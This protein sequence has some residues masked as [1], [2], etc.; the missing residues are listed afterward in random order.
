[1]IKSIKQRANEH[2]MILVALTLLMT[3]F[4]VIGLALFSYTSSQYSRTRTN[5]FVAN[6][7]QVAEAGLEQSLYEINQNESFTGFDTEEV[8][9]DNDTQGKAVYTTEVSPTP[10]SNAKTVISTGKIYRQNDLD[11][12]ISTRKIKVTIVG[13]NSEGYS[14]HTGSG[15]LILSGSANITNSDVYVNGRITMSGAAKIGTNAQPV[16]VNVAHMACPNTA[17][18]GPTYPQLCTSGQPIGLEWS[19]YIYGTVCGTGQ[20]STGP[21]PS[22]NILPG[23]GGQGLVPGCVAEPVSTP[24]YNRTAHINSVN[25]TAA[26]NSNTYVCNS[27]P[28]ERNWPANLKLTGNVNVGGS[29]DVKIRGDV[30]ITGDL[31]LGGAAKITVDESVGTDR[32]VVMVDGKITV[33]G[34]ARVIANS[35]GTGVHFVSFKSSAACTPNCATVTGTDLKNSQNLETVSV[36]GGVNMPG[37]IFQAYWGKVRLAGSGNIGAAAGQTVDMS[38]AGTVTFGTILSSGNRTWTVTSYQQIFEE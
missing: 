7:M 23:N 12:P 21:N 28:F 10:D 26:G 16:E 11:K 38:G 19:T 15:G 1:M 13:T 18:P 27:W 8:F 22:K 20:T 30:Y 25:T 17:N 32:P 31:D 24:T 33:G 5:V 6:A 29:C 9:I 35:S 4:T 3:A 14:V 34:S 37:M 36:G 2:G